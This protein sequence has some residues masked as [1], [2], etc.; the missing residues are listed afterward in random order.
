MLLA[1]VK[2]ARIHS[3]YEIRGSKNEKLREMSKVRNIHW[4]NT[5][6]HTKYSIMLDKIF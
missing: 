1:M 5:I 6:T 4:K 3:L 2:N